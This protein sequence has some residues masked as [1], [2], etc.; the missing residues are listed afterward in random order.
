MSYAPI[1][2]NSKSYEPIRLDGP[3]SLY[4][5]PIWIKLSGSG[6][7]DEVTVWVG[8]DHIR[9]FKPNQLHDEIKAKLAFVF[10]ADRLGIRPLLN[11]VVVSASSWAFHT[12]VAPPELPYLADIGWR[13]SKSCVCLIVSGDLIFKLRGE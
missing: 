9:H 12:T 8:R 3:R 5:T 2:V 6:E 10:A 11:D 13:V 1:R 7:Q 4:K